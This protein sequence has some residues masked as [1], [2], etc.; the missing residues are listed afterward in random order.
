MKYKDRFLF[1]AENGTVVT[2]KGE[3]IFTCPMDK[4]LAQQVLKTAEPLK[5]VYGVFCGMK[6]GYV[7]THQYTDE[8]WRNSINITRIGA[9]PV[10]Y[11]CTGYPRQGVIF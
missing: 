4:Q 8:F 7:L 9:H 6:N 10:L 2:Y 3:K 11:R 5:R 1:L